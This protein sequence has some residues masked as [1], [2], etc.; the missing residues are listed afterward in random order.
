MRDC[1]LDAS[2]L[3]L[4]KAG[5][6]LNNVP[7]VDITQPTINLLNILMLDLSFN[8]FGDDGLTTFLQVF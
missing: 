8:N 7:I 4:V 2:R 6:A 5:F 3:A 1:D